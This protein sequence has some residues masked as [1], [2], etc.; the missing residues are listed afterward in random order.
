MD[1]IQCIINKVTNTLWSSREK[2][3]YYTIIMGKNSSYGNLGTSPQTGWAL[4]LI[5]HCCHLEILYTSV[6]PDRI[7][8]HPHEL[9]CFVYSMLISL[10]KQ[11]PCRPT[12]CRNSIGLKPHTTFLNNCVRSIGSL[13]RLPSPFFVLFC[14]SFYH[15]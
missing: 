8:G 10:W 12:M 6:L 7:V 9:G 4:G 5:F 3:W 11:N 15:F 1:K 2:E 13:G 14:L